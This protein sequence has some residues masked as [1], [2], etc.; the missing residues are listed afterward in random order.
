MPTQPSAKPSEADWVDAIN[1]ARLREAGPTSVKLR[2]RQIALFAHDGSVLACNNRCPHEGYPLCE[3]TLDSA[4][5][6]TCQWH[7]WKFDLRTGAN[8]YGGDALR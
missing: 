6:L 7:N 3:G 5:L 1:V 2:G 4:G 8:R